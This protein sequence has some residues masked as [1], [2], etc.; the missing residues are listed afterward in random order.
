MRFRPICRNSEKSPLN[1]DG[2]G[3]GDFAPHDSVVYCVEISAMDTEKSRLFA[4]PPSGRFCGEGAR[5]RGIPPDL[6]KLSEISA[7][8]GFDGGELRTALPCGRLCKNISAKSRKYS[9]VRGSAARPVLRRRGEIH[10][11]SARSSEIHRMRRLHG[12]KGRNFAPRDSVCDCVEI[13]PCNDGESRRPAGPPPGRF[14]GE[15]GATF[16]SIG[17]NSATSPVTWAEMSEFRTS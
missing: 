7:Y 8:L 1:W 4:D 3:G 6:L 15:G 10:R 16:R 17:R 13:S 14:C 2:M 9:D 11:Y 5:F 12:A